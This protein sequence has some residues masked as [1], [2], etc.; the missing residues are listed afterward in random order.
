[1]PFLSMKS[2]LLSSLLAAVLGAACALPAALHAQT[3]AAPAAAPGSTPSAQP[4]PATAAAPAATPPAPVLPPAVPGRPRNSQV[5]YAALCANCHGQSFEGNRAPTMLDDVW[6]H[7]GEDADLVRSIRDGWP[8]NE[9]PGFGAVLSDVEIRGMVVLIREVRG[10]RAIR[11]ARIG[12]AGRGG[13][14]RGG[15]QP[16]QMSNPDG[17][18]VESQLETFKIERVAADLQTPWGIAFLP[19]GRLIVTERPGRI[20]IIEPGKGIVD[21]I[22]GVPPIWLQQDGGLFDIAVH[23]DYARTG[24]IYFSFSETGPMQGTSGT[25]IMR[26]RI[27]DHKLVDLQ[28]LFRPTPEL[29]WAGNIHYGSRFFFDKAGY[30]FYSIGDRGHRPDAQSLASPYGKLHRIRD[31]GTI[32]DDN[33]FVKTP[34]ALPSVWSYGHRNQQGIAQHPVTG[35]L[36]AT[37][38][39]PRGGDEL[40]LILKGHNYG[41]PVITHGNDDDGTPITDIT[42]KEG[43][44]QPITYWTPSIATSA[45]DFYTGDKF[46]KWKNQLFLAALAGQQFRRL[47]LDGH[48]VVKQEILFND[49][50]RVREVV[51]GPDGYLYVAVNTAFGDSPGQIIRLV[52]SAV[53]PTATK[54]PITAPPPPTPAPAVAPEPARP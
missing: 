28:D 44:D 17:R 21:T 38:H 5:I 25:R 49:L 24:W 9:M 19:D 30:L 2:R 1:M 16:P 33:P 34:G 37:E 4:A 43:M 11:G 31:D 42:E 54:S 36:F 47:E 32:P 20:R 40:N 46:P 27:Q 10:G 29:Y 13:R 6:A 22:T 3:P 15:F 45:I 14:G 18:I 50:G 48:K 35:E 41:W 23:P 51:N 26:A 39:G 8:L 53:T 52:P 12:G 7:G